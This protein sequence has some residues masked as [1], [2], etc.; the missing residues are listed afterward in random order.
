[1]IVIDVGCARYGGD[2][3][4][5]RLI[6]MFDPELL[7]GFD[8]NPEGL[9]EAWQEV[10]PVQGERV[11]ELRPWAAWTY[12]GQIGFFADGLNGHIQDH[13]R[14]TRVPCFDLARFI[15]E[16]PEGP[17]VL[18]LDAEGAEYDL[19][20]HLIATDTDGRLERVLVEWHAPYDP[21][22]RRRNRIE[23]VLL[24]SVEEWVW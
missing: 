1:M 24:C 5:E 6:E 23:R 10:A 16:L 13:E 15:N 9:S 3:S 20:E 22:R 21:D 2:Y 17:V 19:L 7:W 4:V 12:D 11:I 8:P 18:K 14:A